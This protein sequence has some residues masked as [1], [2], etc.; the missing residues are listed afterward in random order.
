MK[1]FIGN[2]N[3]V[4]Y[5][6][7]KAFNEAAR[8]AMEE[9]PN[10]L[11]ITS[12]ERYEPDD[13]PVAIPEKKE[14]VGVNDYII[15][16]ESGK[17]VVDGKTE[18]VVPEGLCERLSKCDNRDEV[19]DDIRRRMACWK[20]CLIHE[21]ERLGEMEKELKDTERK[22]ESKKNDIAESEA[23]VEY[24]SKLLSCLGCTDK[25]DDIKNACTCSGTGNGTTTVS[26]IFGE[27]GRIFDNFGSNF[28][29]YLRRK[30]LFD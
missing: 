5:T 28:S 4:E 22:I 9:N 7:R 3:G 30:G 26:D 1:K 8:K 19:A 25:C 27:M 15:E 13:E 10:L 23:G 6:D 16:R 14:I 2:V 21:R 18:F 24:Y 29:S 20:R 12:Y 17:K 11:S